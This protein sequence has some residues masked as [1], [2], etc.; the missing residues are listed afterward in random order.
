MKS[1]SAD[2]SKIDE[3]RARRRTMKTFFKCAGNPNERNTVIKQTVRTS[4]LN[5]FVSIRRDKS[6]DLVSW[7]FD[8]VVI[9]KRVCTGRLF[10][11]LEEI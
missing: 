9:S 5:S 11:I 1:F 4:E 8:S 3:T 7:D 10:G 6:A 2:E